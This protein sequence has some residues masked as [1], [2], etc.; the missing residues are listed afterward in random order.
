M[1]KLAALLTIPALTLGGVLTAAIP[2][3]A[4]TS[5]LTN[6]TFSNSSI[7]NA[8]TTDITVGGTNP[9]SADFYGCLQ[10][11][12][13]SV[14]I[15]RQD[16]TTNPLALTDLTAQT[17]ANL[18]T[19]TAGAITEN[20]S[21]TVDD[22]YSLNFYSDVACVDVLGTPTISTN[23][24]ILP[25][26]AIGTVGSASFTE[27]VA[28]SVDVSFTTNTGY[29]FTGTPNPWTEDIATPLPTG[30]TLTSTPV[31]NS[32]DTLTISG[33][34]AAGT[35]GVYTVNLTLTDS[36]GNTAITPVQI[37]ITGGTP[38]TPT[39]AF[40][41]VAEAQVAVP[42]TL[43]SIAYTA[44]GFDWTVPGA[45]AALKMGETL[46]AG[47]TAVFSNNVDG[48]P[49]IA[50]TGT[51]AAGTEG[52]YTIIF[53]L[54]DGNAATAELPLT[55]AVKPASTI[56]GTPATQYTTVNTDANGSVVFSFTNFDFTG[57]GACITDDATL[58]TGVHATTDLDPVTFAPTGV[59]FGGTATAAGDYNVIVNCNDSLGNKGSTTIAYTV[60]ITAAP[61]FTLNIGA[62]GGLTMMAQIEGS[63]AVSVTSNSGYDFTAGG[64]T[65]SVTGLPTGLSA[66][67]VN[68]NTAGQ[69]PSM[70]IVGKA[71]TAGTSTLTFTLTDSLGNTSQTNADLTVIPAATTQTI[72][73]SAQ[74]GQPVAGSSLAYTSEGLTYNTAWTLVVASTPTTIASGTVPLG[75]SISGTATMPNITYA[76]G[77]HTITLTAVD[78]AGKPAVKVISFE[79]DA[80]G[81]LIKTSDLAYTGDNPQTL[82]L[83]IG[84]AASF[85]LLGLATVI[86]V[87]VNRRKLAK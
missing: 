84:G 54:T 7:T 16:F 33:T 64:G 56:T 26:A 76:A 35:T 55:L 70:V 43:T 27:G 83:L 28:G 48:S 12:K 66:T 2:A 20:T 49:A 11:V 32:A 58:P 74:P 6:F 22:V 57:G 40:D 4:V 36:L 78:Y 1:K 51:P 52:E 39:A 9:G 77:W 47:L 67:V 25:K 61:T 30:L 15:N 63:T 73:M 23:I 50:I 69:T 8:G 81:N 45:T 82:P 53:T 46:P 24:T 86:T 29:D 42:S 65:M 79:V 10:T 41:T 38:A 87:M 34:P 21:T 18:G 14:V 31:T 72:T 37:D 59:S 62:L 68:E 75:G 44:A 60:G 17:V 85:L 13:D 5:D 3:A 71:P 80:N 19:L